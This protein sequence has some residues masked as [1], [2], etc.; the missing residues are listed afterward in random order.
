M[1]AHNPF[2]FSTECNDDDDTVDDSIPS[3]S[4]VE[5]L[6]LTKSHLRCGGRT[7]SKGPHKRKNKFVCFHENPCDLINDEAKNLNFLGSHN[8]SDINHIDNAKGWIPIT[9]IMDSGAAESVA[10]L[11]FAKNIPLTDSEGSRHGAAGDK[12]ANR[13]EKQINAVR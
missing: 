6:V 11:D 7:W 1:K 13:G 4:A 3:V 10:P 9:A 8:C 5:R 12:I 2:D